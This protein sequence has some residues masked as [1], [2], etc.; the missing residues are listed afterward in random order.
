MMAYTYILFSASLDRFYI[1][2]TETSPEIRLQKHLSNH[3][4]F[5]A[6]A[7]DWILVWS[8][9]F[10]SKSEAFAFERKIKQWKSRKAIENLI[11]NA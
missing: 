7:K 10:D 11:R 3:S 8:K 9:S 1:G 4:G 2:H 6:K 5:T